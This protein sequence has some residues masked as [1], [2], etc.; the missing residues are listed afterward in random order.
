MLL[1]GIKYL[2]LGAWHGWR[3]AP[4]YLLPAGLIIATHLSS[5]GQD[6]QMRTIQRIE[7]ASGSD[8]DSG[9]FYWWARGAQAH[10]TQV[11]KVAK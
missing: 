8:A 9:A 1:E 2:P 7:V 6:S 4:G 11:R 10:V 5:A 3:T